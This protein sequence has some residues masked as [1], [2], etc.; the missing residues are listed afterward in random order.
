MSV[1]YKTPLMVSTNLLKIVFENKI[2]VLFGNEAISNYCASQ[3]DSSGGWAGYYCEV[4]DVIGLLESYS[5]ISAFNMVLA[6]ELIHWTGHVSRLNRLHHNKTYTTECE[7]IVA[8]IGSYIL[9]M[10]AG[11][12]LDADCKSDINTYI[13]KY[14][15]DSDLRP[16]TMMDCYYKAIHAVQYLGYNIGDF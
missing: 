9:C 14:V 2:K 16:Y 6:H 1:I 10:E 5:S 4:D 12:E 8:N 7:E 11:I 13:D 3:G 15:T